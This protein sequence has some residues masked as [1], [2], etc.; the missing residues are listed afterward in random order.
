MKNQDKPQIVEKATDAKFG[1]MLAA[2]MAAQTVVLQAMDKGIYCTMRMHHDI[3]VE[4]TLYLDYPKEVAPFNGIVAS[5]R[6]YRSMWNLNYQ[7]GLRSYT[8][9]VEFSFHL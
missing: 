6:R 5:K 8:R 9:V 1:T 7:T 3:L 4:V 2:Y